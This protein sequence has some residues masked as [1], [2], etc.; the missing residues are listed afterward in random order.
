LVNAA[1]AAQRGF[2]AVGQ[3]IVFRGLPGARQTTK[4]DRLPHAGEKS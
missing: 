2:A 4:T 3:T 1:L